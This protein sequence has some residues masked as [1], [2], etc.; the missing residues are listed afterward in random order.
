M[1][2]PDQFGGALRHLVFEV[3]SVLRELL[4]TH[5]NL[6]QH[7]VKAVDEATDFV[8]VLLGGPDGIVIGL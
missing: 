2:A 6:R 4:V 7:R 3:I 1:I 8:M 5:L